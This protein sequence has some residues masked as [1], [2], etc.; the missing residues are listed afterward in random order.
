MVTSSSVW[1]MSTLGSNN[2]RSNLDNHINHL[3]DE[4]V[5]NYRLE[6]FF[7]APSNDICDTAKV[8]TPSP[9]KDCDATQKVS[10]DLTGSTASGKGKPSC[11][12]AVGAASQMMDQWFKFT[13][14]ADTHTL[15]FSNIKGTGTVRGVLYNNVQA[16]G[17]VITC[18][19]LGGTNSVRNCNI[20]FI[21]TDSK[22]RF[23]NLVPGKEYIFRLYTHGASTKTFDM[24]LYTPPPAI[25]VSP[26]GE[27]YTV[28]ELIKEVLV[29]ATC[30]LVT[31]VS[32]QHGDG[33][34]KTKVVNGIGYF[35]RNGADFGFD[36]GI[37]LGT[38]HVGH[39]GRHFVANDDEVRNPPGD[40]ATVNAR[41]WTGDKD[42]NDLIA[43]SGGGPSVDY[44]SSQVDFDFIP[45]QETVSFEYLFGSNSYFSGCYLECGNG[46]M[47]G[48]WLIDTVT[49]IG[50]NLALIP[51]TATTPISMGTVRDPTKMRGGA[52]LGGCA[53]VNP[54]YF[55]RSFDINGVS[56]VNPNVESSVDLAAI[57]VPIKSSLV[58]VVPGRKYHIRL[59]VLDF[60]TTP[61]HTS[62]VFF[63]AGSFD[64]GK[65]E[66]GTNMS[67]EGGNAACPGETVE[68]GVNLNPKHYLIQW[69]KDGKDL[70]GENGAVLKVKTP[71]L[72]GAKLSYKD[73]VCEIQPQSVL[74]EYYDEII[75]EKQ[76]EDVDV[77]KSGQAFTLVNLDKAMTG[78]TYSDVSLT[79]H[80]TKADAEDVE[81]PFIDP[82]YLVDNS[83]KSKTVWVRIKRN[84][85]DCFIV[86]SFKINLVDCTLALADLPN[87]EV[88]KDPDPSVIPTFDLT[89]YTSVV[90]YGTPGYNV[91]YYK[92]EEDAKL[93]KNPITTNTNNYPGTNGE[94]IWVRVE[95]VSNNAIY[96]VTSFNLVINNLPGVNKNITPLYACLDSV[97]STVGEF[98]LRTKDNE[99]TQSASGVQIFYYE[100]KKDAE[101]GLKS[102]ALDKDSYFSGEKEVYFRV[103]SLKTGCSVVGNIVLKLS[104]AFD[105]TG[106]N[107]FYKCGENGYATFNLESIAGEKTKGNVIPLTTYYYKTYTD[108]LNKTNPIQLTNG[109]YTNEL[110]GGNVVYLRVDNAQGCY[111]IQ[112][113]ELRV[114]TAPKTK[115][116]API[117]VCAVSAGSAIVV[118]VTVKLDEILNGINPDLVNVRYYTS[119]SLAQEGKLTTAI[120]DPEHFSN[121]MG[122]AVYVRVENR[123][124][125]CFSIETITLKVNPLPEVVTK[126]SDYVLCDDAKLTG[127]GIFNLGTYKLNISAS[128]EYLIS[129]HKTN[130][131]AINSV[132]LLNEKAYKNEVAFSQIIFVR[133]QDVKTGCFVIRQLLLKVNEYP[134]YDTVNGGVLVACTSSTSSQGEFNLV[135]AAQQNI[136]NH[137]DFSFTFYE[138][139]GDAN[140][141]INNIKDPE[142]YVTQDVKE[143][144][145]W[146]RIVNKKTNCAGIYEIVLKVENAPILPVKLPLITLCDN[147]EDLFD[148]VIVVDITIHEKEIKKSL[149]NNHSGVIY[150]YRT[151]ADAGQDINRIADPTIYVNIGSNDKVW[152]RL[153]DLE[154]ACYAIE[155]FEIKVN[156]PLRLEEPNPIVLCSDLSIGQNKA[157]FDLTKHEI[158]I[159]GGHPIFGVIYKYYESEADALAQTNAIPTKDI[160][161]YVNKTTSQNIWIVITNEVGCSSMV[162]QKITADAM[163]MPNYKPKRL[164]ACEIDKAKGNARFD[165][166]TSISDIRQG[167]S[168]LNLFYFATKVAAEDNIGALDETAMKSYASSSGKVYVRVENKLSTREEKCFVIVE[169][170]LF[171]NAKPDINVTPYVI[172]MDNPVPNY[173]FDFSTK[174]D[175]ILNGRDKDSYRVTFHLTKDLAEINSA[176][177]VYKYVNETPNAQT[178]FIRL[179]DRRTGCYHT[180]PLLLQIEQKVY[181]YDLVTPENLNELIKCSDASTGTAEFNFSKFAEDILNGQIGLGVTYY[182]NEKNYADGK[183]IDPINNVVLPVGKYTI[184]A[185]VKNPAAG[186]YCTAEMRFVVEVLETPVAPILKNGDIVCVDYKTGK[187]I[188]PYVFDSGFDSVKYDF[189]W[190]YLVSPGNYK[191]IAGATKSYYVVDNISQGNTFRVIVNYKGGTCK[192][193]SAVAS[194]EFVPEINIKVKG[195]DSTGLIGGFDNDDNMT[196]EIESPN[197]SVMYEYALDGGAYQDSRFFYD[198]TNGA[199]KVWVRFKDNKSICPQY[200][201]IFVL[202]YPKFFTPNGDGFND[203]WNITQL[204]GHPEAVIYIFDR[205][206]KLITQLRP[207]GQGWDG[208]F[209]G[210]PLPA[211]DYWF[212]VEYLQEPEK[213]NEMPRKVQHKGHFSLKR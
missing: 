124:S 151:S 150:Y 111:K 84:A 99:I 138:N 172:C 96:S 81:G 30:D 201:D 66:L 98:M 1:A 146:I 125:A 44:R 188:E 23:E 175:E 182:L 183:P 117:D 189:Q 160:K 9:N 49:G 170:D 74:V 82:N 142:S 126:L 53:S 17:T 213:A 212:T 134:I 187:L 180:A 108:A 87:M 35:D 12:T 128:N 11:D 85:T 76:P 190:E 68:L 22:F 153:V 91:T 135:F 10:V 64:I 205:Y 184:I 158:S 3:I 8:V 38:G 20:S 127:I 207:S 93:K 15:Q 5:S 36:K 147:Y 14:I 102:K 116:P 37:V 95:S 75:L 112:N 41:R 133:I 61:S 46:A 16:N 71:G 145:V 195:A 39:L 121:S 141:A 33:S 65:P 77:C 149:L 90:Y 103:E 27:M 113:I 194:V 191:E 50:S 19:N 18:A 173:E 185:V 210:K 110:F 73:V 155:S 97:T 140:K 25:K 119:Y 88:C 86:T 83:T 32:Y 152:Y 78:V 115:T 45:V 159:I 109:L 154:T 21:N 80:D 55:D 204:K 192:S 2:L 107:L 40:F 168:N 193:P 203:T 92:S 132:N 24:C 208:T 120:S 34:A 60:C 69:T 178:I 100:M 70:P 148:G 101:E 94:K 199:H 179:E 28:D 129:Y 13:A 29:T 67:I 131:D 130:D 48:A 89:L 114:E 4:T 57:S 62:A 54:E 51:G 47:F 104:P 136:I 56:K 186:R 169:L 166:T 211:T 196:I 31:N 58:K 181:A 123:T 200:I 63:N 43:A 79:Y 144:K 202:G 26:S 105:L 164:E 165:L 106:A 118:D 176:A 198:V 163:P 197:N 157:K 177:L 143:S 174:I 6:F 161:S 7:A 59:A 139:L 72:Y 171:V 52:G 42:L 209:N 156:L 167:D 206:G 162:I 122:V 137:S